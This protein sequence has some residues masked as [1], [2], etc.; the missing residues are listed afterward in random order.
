[1]AFFRGGLQ[2]LHKK[3]KSEIFDTTKNNKQFADLRGAMLKKG[4]GVF[5]CLNGG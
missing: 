2:L 3:N 1:M 5:K 4:D